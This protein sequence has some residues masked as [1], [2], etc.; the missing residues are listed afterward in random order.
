MKKILLI[1]LSSIGDIVLTTPVI[2]ALKTQLDCE[3]HVL[4]KNTFSGLYSTNP[5]IDT[6]HSFN[7][8]LSEVIPSLRATNFD[9]VVD[10]QKNLRS[11]RIKQAL[12]KPS[13]S[14]PKLN[15]QKWLLVNL[16][17]NRLPQQHIVDRYFEAVASLGVKND[18]KGLDYFIPEKT[19]V[20]LGDFP[21]LKENAFVGFVIGGKHKTKI[22]P[23]EKTAAVINRLPW[24]VVLLGGPENSQSGE[25]IK[26]ICEKQDV[27]NACGKLSLDQSASI[28][29]QA[30][31][32]ITNDTGLM[33]IAA[34]FN[35]PIISIWGNTI[36]EFG[37]KPY[38][39]DHPERLA[40]AEVKG[41]KCRPCSKIGYK[42]CPKGHFNCMMQQD[43]DFIVE[44]ALKLFHVEKNRETV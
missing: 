17:L 20:N 13:A 27:L 15:T 12:K 26:E 21:P 19:G 43:D 6:I 2:R 28:V 40:I 1:R 25:K 7:K 30:G 44:K 38:E 37:M 4:T 22:F 14:F 18:G 31:L 9:F 24:P 8:K 42:K 10:L 33:H 23:A 41:L 11:F 3:L 29:R 39:P 16:K 32:V 34:A 36:P 5:H 35:K